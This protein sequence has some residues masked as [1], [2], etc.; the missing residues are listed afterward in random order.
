MGRF[1]SIEQKDVNVLRTLGMFAILLTLSQLGVGQESQVKVGQP[2]PDFVVTGANG[3]PFKLSD[4]LKQGKHL[5][6]MFSRAHW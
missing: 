3:K 2:A 4:K 6:L 1:I 5:V